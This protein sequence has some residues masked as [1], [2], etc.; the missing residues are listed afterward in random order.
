MGCSG[1]HYDHWLGVLYDSRR[2]YLEQ[3]ARFFH[4]VEVNSTFYQF[5]R[6]GQLKRWY[7][8]TPDDFVFTVKMNRH[9]THTKRL[10]ETSQALSDFFEMCEVLGHKLGPV[11][12]GLS[13][14]FKKDIDRLDEFISLLPDHRFAFEFRHD[15]W[16]SD[17][18]FDRFREHNNLALVIL[19]AQFDNN[20]DCFKNFAYIRWHSRSGN[21]DLYSSAELDYWERRI[22]EMSSKADVFGYWNHEVSGL[23]NCLDLVSSLEVR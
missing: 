6:E 12:L 22:R 13:S 11:L 4:S 19:G 21:L 18:V 15:S 23:K 9:I 3:Y 10:H 5:P 7:D 16:F 1:W 17:E 20:I 8:A 2:N 14:S